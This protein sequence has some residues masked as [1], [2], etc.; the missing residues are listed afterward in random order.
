MSNKKKILYICQYFN[1]PEEGGLLRPWEVSRYLMSKGYDVTVIAASPHHMSGY[2]DRKIHKK[3]FYKYY[4]EGI[5]VIKLY[6][7]PNYR[8]SKLSRILY[9]TIYPFLAIF[10]SLFER[11]PDIIITTT[12]PIFLLISGYIVSKIKNKK[13]IIEVRDAW[14][15]FA[16][17]R[18]LVP[19]F[20][21]NPLKKLQSYMFKKADYIISVTPG[22]K[23]MVDNYVN[24]KKSIL[25]MNGFEEDVNVWNEEKEREAKTLVERYELNNKFVVIYTGTFGMARDLDIFGRTAKYLKD[26]KDIVFLFIGEGEKKKDLMD[27]CKENGLKNCIFLPLQPRTMIPLFLRISDV[28]INA[29]RK[30]DALES[31]LSNKIFDYLGNGLPVIWAGEGD[32]EEFLKKSG[33]GIVVEP[34]NAKEMANAILKLYNDPQLKR[35]M[36]QKG[37]NYVLKNFTRNKVIQNIDIILDI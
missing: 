13:F 36:S 22:I 16:I 5:K 26:Y 23:K 34:E 9:Y 1:S 25:V 20:L 35:K 27:F 17:A 2:I 29:I 12:P 15:E 18:N 30:N 32:T 4:I 21:I 24:P 8:S 3:I 31:S 37:R 10:V 19:R 7:Y 6:S 11:K 14:L 28:G 33:G